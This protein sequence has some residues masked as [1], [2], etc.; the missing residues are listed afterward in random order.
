MPV[1]FLS[2]E[3]VAAYGRFAGS[4]RRAQLERYFFLDDVDWKLVDR[5]AHV[6]EQLGIVDSSCFG[7]YAERLPTQ[8]E[9]LARSGRSSGIATLRTHPRS[10]ASS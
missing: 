4:P 3:Q 1:E 2:D 9:Q 5:V 10:S 8:H 6:A 7:R